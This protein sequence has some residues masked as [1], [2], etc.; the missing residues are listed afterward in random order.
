MI[1]K[2]YVF[3]LHSNEDGEKHRNIYLKHDGDVGA[4]L[5][6]LVQ[7]T[8]SRMGETL[9]LAASHKEIRSCCR[10]TMWRAVVREGDS[11]SDSGRDKLNVIDNV[12]RGAL[13]PTFT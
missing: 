5:P 12:P 7:S 13:C 4:V 2:S 10:C 11:E 3:F 1:L 6:S 9:E 8:F